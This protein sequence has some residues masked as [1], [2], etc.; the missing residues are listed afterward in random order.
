MFSHSYVFQAHTS[1]L[2]DEVV[3]RWTDGWGKKS[4]EFYSSLLPFHCHI[5]G[6]I[7]PTLEQKL[8]LVKGSLWRFSQLVGLWVCFSMSGSLFCLF[9]AR[10]QGHSCT[11]T[12]GCRDTQPYQWLCYSRSTDQC[13]VV[14]CQDTLQCPNKDREEDDCSLVNMDVNNT[15]FKIGRK[16]T[17]PQGYMQCV[18][19]SDTEFKCN[20]CLQWGTGDQEPSERHLHLVP[21]Q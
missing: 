11:W 10:T 16:N 9:C 6:L 17:W 8:V 15:I 2:C 12:P 7:T 18:L 1:V 14:M 13:V 19:V 4:V 3:K 20:F 5:T 21:F